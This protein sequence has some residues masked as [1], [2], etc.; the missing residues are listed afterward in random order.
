MMHDLA[1]SPASRAIRRLE[2]LG[3]Q[4][5]DRGAQASGRLRE[6]IHPDLALLLR[7]LTLEAKPADRIS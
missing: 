6:F 3:G 5:L 4:A 7:Y 2:L 1:N